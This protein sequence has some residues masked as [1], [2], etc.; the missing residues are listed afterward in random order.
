MGWLSGWT[1]RKSVTLSR[2]SGA[3]TDYQMKL[4]VGESA[5]A[6][7]ADVDC[8][9]HCQADFDDL[10]FTTSDGTTLLSYWIES[11]SGTTPNQL[12][13]VWVEFNSIGTSAT[14]FYVYYGNA[15]AA[16]YS[17]IEDTFIFG[18][19]FEDG[20]IDTA[21]WVKEKTGNS[22]FVEQNGRL[23][24]IYG[25]PDDTLN[26]N[27]KSQNTFSPEGKAYQCKARAGAAHISGTQLTLYNDSEV[28][29]YRASLMHEKGHDYFRADRFQGSFTVL[30]EES[31]ISNI[32]TLEIRYPAGGDIEFYEGSIKRANESY[33]LAAGAINI[34]LTVRIMSSQSGSG[35]DYF[36]YAFI[37]KYVSPEPVWGTWG[38]ENAPVENPILIN[39][40][41]HIAA[42]AA[43]PTTARLT[44]PDGKTT[45]SFQAGKIS[46]DTNPLPSIDLAADKYTEL[47]WAFKLDDALASGAEIELRVTV[48]GAA[49]NNYEAIP[50]ITIGTAPVGS[51]LA[52]MLQMDHFNG[53]AL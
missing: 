47:E 14:T 16:A 25:S 53:G 7:G 30:Y 13:T 52:A 45:A 3:V 17:N 31:W 23:E 4:L 44:P 33:N 39:A 49:L 15:S 8:G 43:D 36:E 26:L 19:D 29:V 38:E 1:Y 37:R 51:A 28:S 11:V 24:V 46:D 48:A 6:T 9:G 27:I 2:A 50:K 12:A 40:S 5:G 32:Q 10:R 21:R 20:S 34:R 42:G 35:T 41:T 18:D 22:D